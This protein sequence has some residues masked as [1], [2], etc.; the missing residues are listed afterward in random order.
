MPEEL[1]GSNR[2]MTMTSMRDIE[3]AVD[4]ETAAW[5]RQDAEELVSLFHPDMVWPW[6]PDAHAHDPN[7]WVLP[8]G[9][10]I[11][12]VGRRVGRSCSTATSSFTTSGRP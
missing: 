8:W 7:L 9:D 3:A 11:A 4:R 2:Q 6:P 1:G 10:S 12:S 5:D